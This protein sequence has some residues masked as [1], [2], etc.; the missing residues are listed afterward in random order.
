MRVDDFD[1]FLRGVV[2]NFE[3]VERLGSQAP[4]APLVRREKDELQGTIRECYEIR[5]NS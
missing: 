5:R 2:K 1:D 3:H 4:A